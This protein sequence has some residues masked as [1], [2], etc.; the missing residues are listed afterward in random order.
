V[1]PGVI[2]FDE[3]ASVSTFFGVMPTLGARVDF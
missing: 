1:R 2:H 3:E